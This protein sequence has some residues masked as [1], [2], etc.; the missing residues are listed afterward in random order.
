[1]LD[2]IPS[3]DLMIF[4]DELSPGLL[5][6]APTSGHQREEGVSQGPSGHIPAQE[7]KDIVPGLRSRAG[8][9]GEL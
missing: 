2:S 8:G 4:K 7:P 3:D 9:G 1:M 6:C 5:P